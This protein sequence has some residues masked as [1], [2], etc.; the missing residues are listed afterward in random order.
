MFL[1]RVAK[2]GTT[3]AGRILLL[4]LFSV[5][6]VFS[7]TQAKLVEWAQDP[8]GTRVGTP[9]PQLLL[10]DQIDG[11]E[12]EDLAVAGRSIS[13]GQ[14]FA[15]PDEWIRSLTARVRN[16][17]SE[18]LVA[19]Q[20]TFGFPDAGDG[21]P[22]FVICYGCAKVEREKGVMPGE[23]VE[24]KCPGDEMYD[25]VKGRLTEKGSISRISR[26]RILHM[27][28]T[29][30]NGTKWFSGCIK[31]SDPKNACPISAPRTEN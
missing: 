24:L 28:V 9:K 7:Q 23:E 27:F 5:I 30:P 10:K 26:A 11:V 14:P 1:Q 16:V 22:E 19:I 4:V 12:I 6:S 31:T 18:R 15:A 3:N 8:I 29:L 21:S 17:S 25:W 13:V 2:Q 20:I